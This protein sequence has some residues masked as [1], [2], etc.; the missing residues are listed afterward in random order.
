MLY[1]NDLPTPRAAR[2]SKHP[3]NC[4]GS[5]ICWNRANAQWKLS[6]PQSTGQAGWT[7]GLTGD[8]N[9]GYR[10]AIKAEPE[11]G[12]QRYRLREYP[13]AILIEQI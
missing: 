13:V 4:A 5:H 6:R 10:F 1:A 2:P 8:R 9:P 3:T 12:A 7:T 11:D